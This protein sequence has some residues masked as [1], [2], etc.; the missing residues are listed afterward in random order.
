MWSETPHTTAKRQYEHR[1]EPESAPMRVYDIGIALGARSHWGAVS[2]AKPDHKNHAY[3]T[4]KGISGYPSALPPSFPQ[5]PKLG[6]GVALNPRILAKKYP[7][8]GG[9]AL[10]YPLIGS[11]PRLVCMTSRVEMRAS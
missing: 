8:L 9:K 2:I 6:E 4:M 10:G 5:V 3:E 11:S 7:K 1:A